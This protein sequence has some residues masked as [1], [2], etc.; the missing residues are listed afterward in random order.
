M[1][2]DR[3]NIDIEPAVT[4]LR[5]RTLSRLPGDFSR[6]VYLASSRDCNTGQYYHAALTFHFSSTGASKAIGLCDREIFK[7]LQCTPRPCVPTGNSDEIDWSIPFCAPRRGAKD[8]AH[9]VVYLHERARWD[10]GIHRMVSK[11]DIAVLRIP[12]TQV[13]ND[14]NRYVAPN[15]HHA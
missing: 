6:L 1:G 4:D 3:R 14:G 11:A 13:P 12:D 5:N 15:F 7:P 10:K 2:L 9:L 8:F